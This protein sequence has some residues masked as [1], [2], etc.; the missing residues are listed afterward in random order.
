[1]AATAM[2]QTVRRWALTGG[3]TAITITGTI[4]GASLKSD[5]EQKKVRSCAILHHDPIIYTKP[6]F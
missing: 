6:F 3:I 4:Y 2:H 1:M 5:Q